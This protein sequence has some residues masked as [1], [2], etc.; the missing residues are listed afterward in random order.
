MILEGEDHKKHLT[1]ELLQL[2][3]GRVDQATTDACI[4][5]P[6]F[7]PPAGQGGWCFSQVREVV[8]ETCIAK[9]ALSTIRYFG[10][11]VPM[12]GAEIFRLKGS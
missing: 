9:K 3:G 5:D 8:G 1:C 10:A 7:Q 6:A 4:N 11:A 12:P 2:A